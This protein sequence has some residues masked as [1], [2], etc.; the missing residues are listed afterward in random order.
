MKS[1]KRIFRIKKKKDPNSSNSI[2]HFLV[3]SLYNSRR[4]LGI[5]Y[6]FRLLEIMNI[7]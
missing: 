6:I 5:V 2:V 3:F 7:E 1:E 4:I